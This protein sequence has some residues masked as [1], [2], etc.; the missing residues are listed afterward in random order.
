MSI[1]TITMSDRSNIA[2][3]ATMPPPRSVDKGGNGSDENLTKLIRYDNNNV[4]NMT[5]MYICTV[6]S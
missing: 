6:L 4:C 2:R 5:R 3:S 1:I